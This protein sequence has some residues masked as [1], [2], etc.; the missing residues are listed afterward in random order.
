MTTVALDLATDRLSVAA[1]D[2]GREA[3]RHLAGA[4]RHAGALVPLLSEA[5]EE[6]GGSPPSVTRVVLADGPGSF[7]GLRVAAAFAK[8]LAR[9]GGVQVAT[10]PSLLGRAWRGRGAG[11]QVILATTAALRGEVFAGWYRF[12]EGGIPIVERAAL[13]AMTWD[14]VAAGPTAALI[15]GDA[16][17]GFLESLARHWRGSL[18]AR[19]AMCADARALL[20]IDRLGG[21]VNQDTFDRWEPVYGRPAEAQARW[22]QAHGRH[23]PDPP[24]RSL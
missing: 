12:P 5:L 14:Q 22:E 1:C 19:E 15:G 7:T 17:A 23:L 2:D 13:S 9:E 18:V 11:A 20:A 16:P 24:G 10:V 6:V 3:E 8:A 21:A 4:R